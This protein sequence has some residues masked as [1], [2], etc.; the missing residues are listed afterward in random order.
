MKNEKSANWKKWNTEKLQP[1]KSATQ[2]I[3][4]LKNV[5]HGNNAT[6][7]KCNKKE[8]KTKKVQHEN[9]DKSEI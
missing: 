7:T 5:R 1:G 2:K 9:G 6:W 8:C 4:T 3:A